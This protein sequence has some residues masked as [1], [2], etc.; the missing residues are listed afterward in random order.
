[1]ALL[2]GLISEYRLNNNFN[3]SFG[4]NDATNHGAV[5]VAGHVGSHAAQ[6]NGVDNWI[7]C[8]N[9]N[10]LDFTTSMSMQAWIKRTVD[11]DRKFYFWKVNAYGLMLG[12]IGIIPST[13]Q[14]SFN[15]RSGIPWFSAKSPDTIDDI[16]WHHIVG[17]Y[18]GSF[19]RIFVDNVLKAETPFSGII[20]VN[21]QKLTMFAF[22][23]VGNQDGH[24][25]GEIDEAVLW[26]RG[27]SFGN[28][29]IGEMAGEEIAELYN[30]GAGLELGIQPIK[31]IKNGDELSLLQTT[32]L[33]YIINESKRE[34]NSSTQN[35]E[36]E[37]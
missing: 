17:T 10:D 36:I 16:N 18:D 1:M 37:I 15:I 14:P 31:P 27:L 21:T 6:G 13:N 23:N 20:S 4:A 26:N 33:K 35:R 5:F 24:F 11:T 9:N 25:N 7:D 30:N 12:D 34:V 22:D 32:Q 19:L 29:S 2:D 8:T 3:D 28:V